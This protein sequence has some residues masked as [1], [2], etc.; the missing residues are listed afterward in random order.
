MQLAD[1]EGFVIIDEVP[2]VGMCFWTSKP[3]FD[4]TRVSQ[5]LDVICLNRYMGWYSDHGHLEVIGL[6]VKNELNEWY[7]KFG[8]PIIMTE[9]GAD[10]IAGLHKFPR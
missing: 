5:W 7:T 2:A 4:G 9:C 1:R 6:Q 8:K 3:V 10:T